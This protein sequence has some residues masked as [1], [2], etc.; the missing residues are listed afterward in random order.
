MTKNFQQQ[1]TKKSPL[2]NSHE[3]LGAHFTDFSGYLMP[4]KYTSELEEHKAVREYAGIFDVSHMGK[5]L[6]SG[7]DSAQFV[8][9]I[10][11]A[12][13]QD[14]GVGR[15]KY[16]LVLKS[17]GEVLDDLLCY[18]LSEDEFLLIPNAGNQDTIFAHITDLLAGKDEAAVTVTNEAETY[19]ILAVQGPKSVKVLTAALSELG[20]H[21]HEDDLPTR[22]RSGAFDSLDNE[23]LISRTGYTGE[24]GFELLIP[25]GILHQVWQ[26][27]LQQPAAKPA[28]LAARDT[29]RLEAGYP[30]YGNELSAEVTPFESNLSWAVDM[31]KPDFVGKQALAEA[32]IRYDLIGLTGSGRRAARTGYSI[33]R[34]PNES[35]GSPEIIGEVTS[36]A[37]S[38]TLGY[39]IAFARIQKQDIAPSQGDKLYVDI[40]GKLTEMVVSQTPFVG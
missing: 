6:I 26:T 27:I 28:G 9:E 38:P 22:F 40:R 5:I 23:V 39:P 29:L 3:A 15:I 7:E 31:Q 12:D 24:D 20:T 2:H 21:I 36:G 37:L 14:L 4:L 18:R 13:V 17:S 30:L 25:V 35:E 10:L 34:V 8:N 32:E 1:A 16:S 11:T 33:V 19:G